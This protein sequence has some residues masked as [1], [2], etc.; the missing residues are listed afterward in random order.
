MPTTFLDISE[1]LVTGASGYI[2]I[3]CVRQLLEQGY[4]VR[5]TVRDLNNHVKIE[6]LKKLEGAADRLELVVADLDKD[7]G[8][9]Q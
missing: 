6:P 1:V 9:P 5:G 2:G 8:W 3:H 7:E 4:T